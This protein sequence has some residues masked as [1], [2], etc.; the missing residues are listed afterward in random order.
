MLSYA[1]WVAGDILTSSMFKIQTVSSSYVGLFM[2]NLGNLSTLRNA[3]TYV[4]QEYSESY[5]N[6][7]N[8]YQC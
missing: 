7:A 2:A 8:A 3:T 4:L 5:T 6:W 1:W